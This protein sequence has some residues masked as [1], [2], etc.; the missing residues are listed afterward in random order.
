MKTKINNSEK[1]P[2]SVNSGKKALLIEL[3]LELHSRLKSKAALSNKGLYQ[4][5]ISL[6]EKIA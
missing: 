5:I 1:Q 2:E 3:P 4:Y 6:L